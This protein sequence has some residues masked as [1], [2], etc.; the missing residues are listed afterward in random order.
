MSGPEFEALEQQLRLLKM[1]RDPRNQK[2]F[3]GD[4]MD[5]QGAVE[6]GLEYGQPHYFAPP[7]CELLWEATLQFNL[8]WRLIPRRI[9]R[10]R[11]TR[12]TS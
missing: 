11:P 8:P 4:T 7:I 2:M 6:I 3:I 10:L 12:R 1:V 5:S 9:L